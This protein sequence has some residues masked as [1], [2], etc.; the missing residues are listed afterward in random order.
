M[1]SHSLIPP[2]SPSA[3]RP[4][5][6]LPLT[7]IQQDIVRHECDTL[8]D[9]YLLHTTSS[10]GQM[11][12]SAVRAA[13]RKPQPPEGKTGGL[14]LYIPQTRH[15]QYLLRSRWIY[16]PPF[17]QHQLTQYIDAWFRLTVRQWFCEGRRRGYTQKQICE[18]IISEYGLWSSA[19]NFSMLK[20]MDFRERR[21]LACDMQRTLADVCEKRLR[22]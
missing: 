21:K 7:G 5:V 12:C 6:W 20:K 22:G 1:A 3:P 17:L 13:D 15:N 18:A 9:G 16:I 4:W 2:S 11:I 19:D 8:P 10:I 14:R